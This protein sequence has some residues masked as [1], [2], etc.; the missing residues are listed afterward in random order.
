MRKKSMRK[1]TT[2]NIKSTQ[3]IL[4][5]TEKKMRA[6]DI[7]LENVCLFF[8]FFIYMY[9]SIIKHNNQVSIIIYQ[10]INMN[11]HIYSKAAL[12]VFLSTRL[13]SYTCL[14]YVPVSVH[15]WNVGFPQKDHE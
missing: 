2:K 13:F 3:L 8:F 7:L 12:H 4:K 10:Y 5:F 14:M 1:K 15:Y 9:V 11:L 6:D